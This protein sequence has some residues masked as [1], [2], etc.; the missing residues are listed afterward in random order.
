MKLSKILILSLGMALCAAGGIGTALA[1]V[2]K[3]SAS[4]TSS[5]SYDKAIYLY[6]DSESAT[7][8]SLSDMTTL[9]TDVAQYRHLVV[10]PKSS[11]SVSGTV[12]VSFTLQT[13]PNAEEKTSVMKGLTINVYPIAAAPAAETAEAYLAAIGETAAA[14]TLTP[15]SA[16]GNATFTVSTSSDVHTT[17][18]H[19]A[20]KV[21]YDGTQ[22][23]ST[24]KLSAQ[25]V[26][27]QSFGA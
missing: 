18:Q 26:I 4:S 14:C 11:K 7:S 13:A 1:A 8:A 12:T 6:W 15:S 5:G 24:E 16:T 9:E 27:A 19:Y 23:L 25:L 3:N 10:S 21:V 2:T 22:I 20:I 17:V